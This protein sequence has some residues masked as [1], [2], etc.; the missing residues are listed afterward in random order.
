[1]WLRAV[2]VHAQVSLFFALHI[3]FNCYRC[4]LVVT[5]GYQLQASTLRDLEV[6][7]MHLVQRHVAGGG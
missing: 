1:M 2:T 5:A 6:L 4:T 3:K 7:R